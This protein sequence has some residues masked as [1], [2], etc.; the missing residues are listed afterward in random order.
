MRAYSALL[1]LLETEVINEQDIELTLARVEQITEN[2]TENL[3]D[4]NQ[5]GLSIRLEPESIS[6]TNKNGSVAIDLGFHRE[7]EIDL[8]IKPGTASQSSLYVFELNYHEGS[9][10]NGQYEFT[11]EELLKLA[12]SGH[13]S[14]AEGLDSV[15]E[16]ISADISAAIDLEMDLM[17]G[18]FLPMT[19]LLQS[20]TLQL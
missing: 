9:E 16:A 15:L 7:G 14:L 1:I 11:K 18:W 12:E 6:D 17:G 19:F 3:A 5:P 4:T 20:R 13:E 8:I 2:R 10:L